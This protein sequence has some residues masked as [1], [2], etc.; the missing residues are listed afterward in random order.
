MMMKA[1][2]RFIKYIVFEPSQFV[3]YCNYY[4]EKKLQNAKLPNLA[5]LFIFIYNLYMFSN[6]NEQPLKIAIWIKKTACYV[7]RFVLL[8]LVKLIVFSLK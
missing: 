8:L 4:L 1:R 6:E 5:F 3:S 7:I 2:S